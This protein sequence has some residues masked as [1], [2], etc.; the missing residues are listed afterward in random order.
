MLLH[1]LT[2]EL[3]KSRKTD[4]IVTNYRPY[5][6]I[7]RGLSPLNEKACE[8]VKQKLHFFFEDGSINRRIRIN[9]KERRRNMITNK[10][11]Y[12]AGFDSLYNEIDRREERQQLETYLKDQ[13]QR[14]QQVIERLSEETFWQLFP[15]ILGIDAKLSIVAELIR[16]EDFSDEEII[17]IT[18]N[19]YATYFKE[20]CGYDLSMKPKPSL[21]FNM[22]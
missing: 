19:D 14:F 3:L 13:L 12:F 5:I 15:K 1:E 18:E 21:I 16:F 4:F 8:R 6:R 2:E 10:E 20:L 9:K 17:R 7:N 11:E 22:S